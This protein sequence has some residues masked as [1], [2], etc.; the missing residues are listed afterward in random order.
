MGNIDSMF[1][2]VRIP[3]RDDSFLQF[4]WWKDGDPSKSVT[5]YQMVVHLF[6]ATSLPSCANFCHRKTAEDWKGYF[7]EEIVNT[8]LKNFYVDDCLKSVKSVKEAVIL[9]KD[10]QRLLD[11]GGFHISKWI[12]NSRDVMNSIPVSERAKE[13]KTLDLD[14]D[15]IPDDLVIQWNHWYQDFQKLEDFKVDRCIKPFGFDPV[16]AQLHHF[17]DASET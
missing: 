17:A 7:S 5:E 10:L 13:V 4:L 9:V 14:H 8:V 11:K 6:G 16:T 3:L 1:Y 12:S 2:Q 15:R